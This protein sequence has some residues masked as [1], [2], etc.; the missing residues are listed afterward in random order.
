MCLYVHSDGAVARVLTSLVI[1][2]SSST[3]FSERVVNVWNR[4]PAQID[5]GSLSS[6]TRTVKEAD[7]S[8]FLMCF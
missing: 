4:L 1:L 2:S 8:E 7:L 5:F 3:F 6:F